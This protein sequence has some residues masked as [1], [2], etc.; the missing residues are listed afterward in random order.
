[1]EFL[2]KEKH[3]LIADDF[4]PWRRFVAQL[5]LFGRPRWRIVGEASDGAEVVEKAE[6]SRPDLILLDIRMPK[7][8]GFEAARQTMKI[9]PKTKFLFLSNFDSLEVIEEAL[10]TGAHGYVYKLDAVRELVC[11]VE[12]VFRGERFVSGRFKGRIAV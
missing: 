12:S 4:E 1:M 6:E 8:D 3:I 5:I 10:G 7:L 9:A 2:P 11:A